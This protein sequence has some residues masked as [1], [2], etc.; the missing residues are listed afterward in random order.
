MLVF[1]HG[2]DD[3]GDELNCRA[4][5]L[6]LA[7]SS[8]DGI[9]L[10]VRRTADDVLVARH[11]PH[12]DDGRAVRELRSSDLPADVVT[13]GEVLDIVRGRIVNIEI[14]NY[15]IDPGFDADERVTDL[16][17][18][19]L[20]TRGGQDR[21]MVSSFGPGCLRRVRDRCPEV[22]T[23]VLLY[24]PEQHLIEVL[25]QVAL[26][27]HPLVHPFEP[28]VDEM[29]VR[30]AHERGIDVNAWTMDERVTTMQRL[31]D[32][33]VDGIITGRPERVPRAAR[34]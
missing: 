9:E 10:D 31:I 30:A 7:V 16:V 4:S 25:D 17:L 8:V 15:S 12:L 24:R 27:G 23:A 13:L 32:V 2:S 14:K 5:F 21:V 22:P 29:F 18:D 20:A 26:D 6:R 3:P 28:H 33:G 1:G 19:L 11:D 34:D